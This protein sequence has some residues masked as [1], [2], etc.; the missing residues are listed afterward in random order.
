MF[1]VR[2]QIIILNKVI[3]FM[4]NSLKGLIQKKH[5]FLTGFNPSYKITNKILS[6]LTAIAESKSVIEHAKILPQ[7]EIKL[8]RQ[9]LIRMTHSST[10]IEG[11]RLNLEQVENVIAN[12]KIDAPERD[13]YEV[14]NYFKA[15]KYIEKIV[16]NKQL[17]SERVLLKIHAIATEKTLRKEQSGHFRKGPIY[18][19]RRQ[20]MMKD[21]IMYIGPSAKEV[22]NLCADL[23]AWI[24]E[25]KKQNINPV[26]VAGIIHQ[27]IAAIHPFADG[28]GRTAR[29]MATLILYQRGY[30][31]RHLF[32]LE[33]YY[34]KDRSKYYDAINIGKN[35]YERKVD[36]TSWLEYFVKGFKEEIDNVKAQIL[37][38]PF[39]KIK[40]GIKSKVYLDKDQLQL[41]EFVDQMGKITAK[42]AID[43]LNC[44]KRTAQLKL[45]QLKNISIIV[46]IGKGPSSAYVLK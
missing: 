30:D 35:Y 23:I 39:R 19:V 32:A 37:T 13:I 3:N 6:M 27:E 12:K 36:F 22:P 28:N 45:H 11:N 9:A 38:L 14:Q 15:I 17:I 2:S 10:K 8:R 7:N 42:D 34:N 41:L 16:H 4:T 18:V 24:R 29:A 5:K 21:E 40:N 20:F 44:S 1:M 43:I 46:Q 26:I 31:F 25:S 33:D